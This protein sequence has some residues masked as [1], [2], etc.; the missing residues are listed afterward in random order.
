MVVGSDD[1]FPLV[2]FRGVNTIAMN[3]PKFLAKS[4]VPL[5]VG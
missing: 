4:P 1:P 3:E 5:G 2:N